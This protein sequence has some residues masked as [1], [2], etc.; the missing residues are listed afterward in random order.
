MELVF[1]PDAR[2]AV[3]VMT[4]WALIGKLMGSETRSAPLGILIESLPE[5]VTFCNVLVWIWWMPAV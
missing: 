3:T 4:C 5:K 1:W 2:Y